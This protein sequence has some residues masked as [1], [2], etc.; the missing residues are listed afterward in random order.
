MDTLFRQHGAVRLARNTPRWKLKNAIVLP[1]VLQGLALRKC[2]DDCTTIVGGAA[3]QTT[4]K[5]PRPDEAI[6]RYGAKNHAYA[7]DG[8]S[9][10]NAVPGHKKFPELKAS[11]YQA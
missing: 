11:V 4:E 1:D 5:I 7:G 9:S 6:N 10:E 3:I 2:T 8:E